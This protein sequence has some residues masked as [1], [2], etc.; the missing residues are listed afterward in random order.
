MTTGDVVQLEG[1]RTC[2]A[3]MLARIQPSPSPLP[4]SGSIRRSPARCASR[5]LVW[6]CC[7]SWTRRRRGGVVSNLHGGELWTWMNCWT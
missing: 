7:G 6:R 1:L 5:L 2:T 3:G 4:C